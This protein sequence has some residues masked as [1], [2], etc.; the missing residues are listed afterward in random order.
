MKILE[1]DGSLAA[2]KQLAMELQYTG[3]FAVMNRAAPC[4]G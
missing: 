3:R 1:L 2:H 4:P